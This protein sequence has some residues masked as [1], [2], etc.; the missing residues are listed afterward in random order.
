MFGKRKSDKL[1][2]SRAAI[3]RDRDRRITLGE[4]SGAVPLPRMDDQQSDTAA[5]LAW[6]NHLLH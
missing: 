6:T 1:G 2:A 4:Y 5:L 3:A